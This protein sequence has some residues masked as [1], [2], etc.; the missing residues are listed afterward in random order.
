MEIL[1]I[2]II[3][4]IIIVIQVPASCSPF[5]SMTLTPDIPVPLET[6]IGSEI[7]HS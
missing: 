3:T 4:G 7:L 5:D 6:D 1:N 2:I